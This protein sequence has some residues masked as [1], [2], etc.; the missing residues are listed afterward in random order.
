MT[1]RCASGSERRF[2]VTNSQDVR[3]QASASVKQISESPIT[4]V[5]NIRRVPWAVSQDPVPCLDEMSEFLVS[6]RPRLASPSGRCVGRDIGTKPCNRSYSLV[7]T[8]HVSS[9]VREMGEYCRCCLFCEHTG[10]L[11]LVARSCTDLPSKAH[12]RSG[13]CHAG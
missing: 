11:L 3:Y 13:T 10:T 5:T 4:H 12:R 6:A 9:N 8:S 7:F 1:F 2:L